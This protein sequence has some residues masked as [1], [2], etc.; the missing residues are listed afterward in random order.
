MLVTVEYY[1][2]AELTA[3]VQLWVQPKNII[4]PVTCIQGEVVTL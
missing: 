3:T 4:Y 1:E 2:D